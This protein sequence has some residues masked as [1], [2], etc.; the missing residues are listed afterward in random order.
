ML[1]RLVKAKLLDANQSVHR[2]LDEM[3]IRISFSIKTGLFFLPQGHEE[4]TESK[5]YR[6]DYLE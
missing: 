6:V 4:H 5:D 3:I 2:I 1:F